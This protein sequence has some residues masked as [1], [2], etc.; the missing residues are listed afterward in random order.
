MRIQIS[1]GL[2]VDFEMAE[3]QDKKA[4]SIKSNVSCRD[5]PVLSDVDS[6]DRE[7]VRVRKEQEL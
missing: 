2:L 4:S 7:I 1:K 5:Y 6:I 3:A